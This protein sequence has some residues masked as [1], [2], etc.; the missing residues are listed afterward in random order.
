[1]LTHLALGK[2]IIIVKTQQFILGTVSAIWWLTEPHLSF[3]SK[4]LKFNIEVRAMIR[5]H[6]LIKLCESHPSMAVTICCSN[7]KMFLVILV[8]MRSLFNYLECCQRCHA[9]CHNGIRHYDPHP[10]DPQYN[11]I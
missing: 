1:M 6:N 7:L 4:L 2:K 3:N 10:N 11:D 5:Q 8:D 9:T